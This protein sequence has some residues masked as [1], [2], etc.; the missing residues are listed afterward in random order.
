MDQGYGLQLRGEAQNALVG[1]ITDFS[2]ARKAFEAVITPPTQANDLMDL[3]SPRAL[4]SSS[5]HMLLKRCFWLPYNS[6]VGLSAWVSGPRRLIRHKVQVQDAISN[7]MSAKS[8][9]SVISTART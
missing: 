3:Q 5:E 8:I 7:V 4:N 1:Y 9:F 2:G 6:H